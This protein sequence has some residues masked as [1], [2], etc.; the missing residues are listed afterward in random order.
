MR[1]SSKKP[2]NCPLF[3]H[4]SFQDLVTQRSDHEGRGGAGFGAVRCR[5]VWSKE[6]HPAQRISYRCARKLTKLV[7]G[8]IM[9]YSEMEYVR[10]ITFNPLTFQETKISHLGKRKII[11]KRALGDMLVPRRVLNSN[12]NFWSN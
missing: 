1:R 10:I 5:G 12:E 7:T 11:F 4:P 9:T 3:V 2:N 6:V 8:L